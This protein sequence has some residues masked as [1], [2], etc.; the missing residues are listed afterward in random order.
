MKLILVVLFSTLP[1]IETAGNTPVSSLCSEKFLGECSAQAHLKNI[2]TTSKIRIPKKTNEPIETCLTSAK[3][4]LIS[5]N[6]KSSLFTTGVE[7][8]LAPNTVMRLINIYK[9]IDVNFKKDIT[10]ESKLEV[11][12]E[13]SSEHKNGKEKILYT[14]LTIHNKVI[15][16]YYY[17]SQDGK[18][19]HFDKEGITLKNNTFFIKPLNED[20]RISS[21]FGN[22]KH[23]IRGHTAF[24]KGVDYAT[25]FGTPIYAT[26]DGNIDYIGNNGDYGKY[27]RIKH[28]DDYTTCYAHISKFN[29][30]IKLGSKVKQGQVIA[31]VGSTGNATGPHLHYEIIHHNKHIDPLV[32][33]HKIETKLSGHELTKFKLFI[34]KI[35]KVI[36]NRVNAKT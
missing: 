16:L 23:P 32:L 33:E 4:L 12:L 1:I 20:Y 29:D 28:K 19:G 24:H 36:N 13:R 17:K 9:N 5:S 14:S 27:I 11:L 8:G 21:K 30:N 26:A 35:D 6:I 22:R 3:I 34:D 7:Q 25:K 10:P 15:N 2:S 18:E 31:Y